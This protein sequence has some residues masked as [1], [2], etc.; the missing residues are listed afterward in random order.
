MQALDEQR[1]AAVVL[2]RYPHDA[3]GQDW[4]GRSFF[5]EGFIEAMERRYE[6]AGVVGMRHVYRPKRP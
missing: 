2:E 3:R 5:G 4:Y 6:L 1:F